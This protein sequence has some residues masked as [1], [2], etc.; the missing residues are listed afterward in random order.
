MKTKQVIPHR[1]L[2]DGESAVEGDHISPLK[3]SGQ[4][5]EQ[6]HCLRGVLSDKCDPPAN[7]MNQLNSHLVL[8]P[9]SF[10][11]N[12]ESCHWENYYYYYYVSVTGVGYRISLLCLS[13]SCQSDAFCYYTDMFIE[14]LTC[15]SSLC[16]SLLASPG[17]LL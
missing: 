11:D 7:F 3:G 8:C 16:L 9:S 5:L 17:P 6:K 10:N 2:L 14:S 13:V 1:R 4:A 12:W 15:S